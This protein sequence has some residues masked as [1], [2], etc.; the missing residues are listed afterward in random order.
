MNS[1]NSGIIF[2]LSNSLMVLHDAPLKWV[3]RTKEVIEWDGHTLIK[4]E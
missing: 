2:F 1:P 3:F 4:A